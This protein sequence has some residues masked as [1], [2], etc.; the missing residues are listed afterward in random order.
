VP[1]GEGAWTVEEAKRSSQ[2]NLFQILDLLL[3]NNTAA[4]PYAVSKKGPA[5]METGTGSTLNLG[6]GYSAAAEEPGAKKGDCQGDAGKAERAEVV[7]SNKVY[8]SGGRGSRTVLEKSSKNGSKR[9]QIST[10]NLDLLPFHPHHYRRLRPVNGFGT[11]KR[12]EGMEWIFFDR[13]G[14][15]SHLVALSFIV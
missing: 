11:R 15:R 6:K 1:F 13:R 3:S 5:T 14:K 8:R 7:E 4:V 10:P 9:A 12:R 2:L